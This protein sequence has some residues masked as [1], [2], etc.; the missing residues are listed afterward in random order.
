MIKRA[1]IVAEARKWLGTPFHHQGRCTAG[2]DCAGLVVKIAHALNISD[3]DYVTYAREPDG[4]TLQK[5]MNENLIRKPVKDAK[6]G[7]IYL[8]RFLK[9]PQHLAI[10]TDIGVIHSHSA[11][12]KVVETNLDDKWFKRVL[13]VYSYPGVEQ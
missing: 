12:G 11:A 8:M 7:D 1:D 13:A 6:D 2:I 10:K 3:F 5:I 4:A 9:H